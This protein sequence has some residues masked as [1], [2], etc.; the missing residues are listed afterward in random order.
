VRKHKL[1]LYCKTGLSIFKEILPN[2]KK[3]IEYSIYVLIL[4]NILDITSTYIGIKYF[5]AYEANDKTA[6]F[7]KLFGMVIPAG[8]KIFIVM[9]FGYT[10]RILWMKSEILLAKRNY[11]LNSLAIIWALN[12]IFLMI[13][14][15]IVYVLVV[16]NNIHIIYTN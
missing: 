3:V 5:N 10:M 8:I 9:L 14:L 2:Y 12:A 13:I 6:Y 15:N 11:L 1:K 16:L 7:F 4:L